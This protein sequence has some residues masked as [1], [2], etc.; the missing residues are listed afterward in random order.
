MDKFAR[1]ISLFQKSWVLKRIKKTRVWQ[2]MVDNIFNVNENHFIFIY[3]RNEMYA[4]VI[5][6]DKTL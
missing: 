3:M 1:I 6:L 4:S 2:I 5:V